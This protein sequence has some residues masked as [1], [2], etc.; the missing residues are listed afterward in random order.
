[1]NKPIVSII[2]PV[3]NEVNYIDDMVAS[4]LSQ[5]QEHYELELLLID[6]G[7]KD[8]TK[9]KI[10]TL[11]AKHCIVKLIDNTKRIT[12]A[13]FNKASLTQRANTLLF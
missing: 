6:G 9:E 12:P 8:G 13:A 7:S 4:V 5:K 11:E 3:L 2:V 10:K 1:M